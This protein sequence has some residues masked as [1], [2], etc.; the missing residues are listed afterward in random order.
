MLKACKA[1]D[2][3]L[4]FVNA[5]DKTYNVRDGSDWESTLKPRLH[6]RLRTSKNVILFLS[7]NTKNSRALNEE[8][9]YAINTLG[10][11]IIVVYPDFSTKGDI[12]DSNGIRQ[13]VKTLW[14]KLPIFRDNMSKVATIHIP[15]N[16]ALITS[17]LNDSDLKVQTMVVGEYYYKI[18]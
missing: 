12:A 4:A 18:N 15:M 6:Q 11:P 16:K 14:D 2:S 3:A 1:A 9:D 5:H 7:S 8:I 17:S 13:Q 10:L